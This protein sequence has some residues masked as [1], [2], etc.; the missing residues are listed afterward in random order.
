MA[1]KLSVPLPR[2]ERVKQANSN[3]LTLR[4]CTTVPHITTQAQR[5]AG[6][7]AETGPLQRR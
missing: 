6:A 5:P 1:E 2:R 7:L 3:I 4:C